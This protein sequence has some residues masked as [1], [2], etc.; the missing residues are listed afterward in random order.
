MKLVSCL[1]CL[2]IVALNAAAEFRA[3]IATRVVT[4]EPL[5]PV[6]GGVGA[7]HAVTNNAGDLTVRAIVFDDS[8]TRVAIVSADFL[9]FPGPLCDKVR[10]AV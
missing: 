5:L 6:I 10:A 2:L 1:S 9:G 8:N 3:G 4:P 7:G